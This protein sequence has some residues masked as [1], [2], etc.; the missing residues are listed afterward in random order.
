M[1]KTLRTI[2]AL[3]GLALC[4]ALPAKASTL[5]YG[6]NFTGTP[7]SGSGD[8][9]VD[10][11]KDL[12]R[13]QYIQKMRGAMLGRTGGEINQLLGTPSATALFTDQATGKQWIYNDVLHT[14]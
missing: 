1:S 2:G 4:A 13:G 7:F 8:I 10:F 9:F 12:A 6:F 3:L 5:D 14:S 11:A